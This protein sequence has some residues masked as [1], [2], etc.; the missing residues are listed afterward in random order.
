MVASTRLFAQGTAF[1]YQGFLNDGGHPANG[2]YDLTFTLYDSLN[3]PGNVLAVTA[4]NF[5]TSISNGIFNATM[6]FGSV[7]D[8]NGRWLEIGVRTNGATNFIILNPRQP[9]L[10]VPYAIYAGSVN[11]A[12]AASLVA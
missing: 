8:G 1:M 11:L 9:V 6:D 3:P 10:P 2:T 12:P 5:G 4:T 7:F